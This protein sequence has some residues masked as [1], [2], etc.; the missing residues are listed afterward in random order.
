[1]KVLITHELFPP[2]VAGGGE[3]AV[4]ETA[5]RLMQHGVEIKVL[6]T[7][8]PKIK[9][10]NGIQTIRLPIPRYLMNILAIPWIIKYA[11]DVDLIHTNNYNACFPSFIAAKLLRKPIV[12][13]VH[14]VYSKK[15]FSMRGFIL[16]ALS[17]LVERFQV[18]HSYDKFI[19]F[20]EHMRN[21]A[22]KIGIPLEKTEVIKPGVDFKKFKV[23]KKEPYVLFV[24]NLI[25]RKGLDYLIEVAKELSY[26]KFLIVGRG[27]E[28]K[29]LE[30]MAPENVKFLGYVSEKKLVDLYAKALIFCLPSLGEGF[31]LVLLE[32]MASGCAI[33]STIPLDYE[34]FKVGMGNVDQLVNSIDWLIKNQKEAKKMGKRNREK[35]KEYD[36][37]KF[38]KRLIKIYEE[39]VED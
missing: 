18:C 16:G 1:M 14:E 19:F 5:K 35:V 6:T 29:R 30:A 9:E 21:S 15:W 20:S 23:A 13:H 17:M 24:G 22:V 3:I 7:G 37:D 31:G 8:N 38:I 36:W 39:L 2:D 25:R 11:R 26:V 33:V 12:C 28:K 10:Y 34:G 4:Y 27:K 32:A